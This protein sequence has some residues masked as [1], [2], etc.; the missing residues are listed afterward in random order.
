MPSAVALSRRMSRKSPSGSESP[1]ST[2]HCDNGSDGVSGFC[3]G[4]GFSGGVAKAI[5]PA[6]GCAFASG[7]LCIT[8]K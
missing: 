2:W 8:S 7:S 1:A 5:P 6:N 3:P 4:S